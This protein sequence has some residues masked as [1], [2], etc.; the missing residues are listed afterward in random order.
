MSDTTRLW[1]PFADQA[2]VKEARFLVDRAEGVWVFDADGRRYLDATAGLWYC[3]VGHG[4]A[5]I[6]EA[7]AA[8][9]R[10]LDTYFVFNDYTN[11]PS[12]RLASRLSELAPMDDAT[13][14]LTTGGGESI[15]TAAKLARQ[16]WTRKGEPERTH[17]ISRGNAYHGSN[18]MGTS[19]T[20]IPANRTGFGDLVTDTS[21]VAHDDAEELA[22]A[23]EEIG[24]ERVAAFF[25][26][27]VI[28][29]GGL[30]PPP[31]GYLEKVAEICARYGVL[32]VADSVIC[33]FGRLGTWF[34]VERWNLR[35]DMI[36]FAKGVTSGYL[37][38]GGVIVSGRVSEPFWTPGGGPFRH[39]PTY[40]GHP[41]VTAAALANLDILGSDGLLE[42]GKELEGPLYATLSGLLEHPA[43]TEVRGGIGLLGAVELAPEILAADPT[44]SF[45]A[46]KAIRELGVI[47]RPLAKGLAV[48]PPLTVTEDE[49][50]TIGK[51]ISAGLD[52]FGS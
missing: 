43:V 34:G 5:E 12:E 17:I 26:E 45:R 16:Y 9:M 7:A 29:A 6:V 31:E 32:F 2:E 40:S 23:I 4:R 25:A 20:G 3:N 14:F 24:P 37:P 50:E 39:G 42:R 30:Y 27:P 13:V 47:T 48:S 51:T 35:P 8:Q 41:T 52:T 22:A 21:R 11:E 44:A 46:A 10:K 1:H 49:I 15:D 28:G 33:G 38:L 18:G 19:I 36:T